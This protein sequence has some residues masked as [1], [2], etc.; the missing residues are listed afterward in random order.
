MNA[1]TRVSRLGTIFEHT[2]ASGEFTM[3]FRELSDAA[4]NEMEKQIQFQQDEIGVLAFYRSQELWALITTDRV[5]WKSGSHVNCLLWNEIKDASFPMSVKLALTPTTKLTNDR[6]E[7]TTMAGRVF[8]MRLEPGAPL[9][10]I[11]NVLKTIAT[12]DR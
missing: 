2:G 8:E 10:G 11:W 1:Q 4:K 12:V 7:L 3:P 5:I 6:L 9:I